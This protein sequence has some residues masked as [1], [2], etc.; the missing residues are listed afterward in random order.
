MA[1]AVAAHRSSDVG[2]GQTLRIADGQVLDGVS[3]LSR[4]LPSG[5]VYVATGKTDEAVVEQGANA[6]CVVR[7]MRQPTLSGANMDLT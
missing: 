2:L 3:R 5:G 4:L 1:V 6:V 7:L